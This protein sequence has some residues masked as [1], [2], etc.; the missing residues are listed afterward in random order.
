MAWPAER[1][2]RR[3][4]GNGNNRAGLR[5]QTPPPQLGHNI[6]NARAAAR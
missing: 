2:H 5:F 1:Q 3:K 6:D 4:D